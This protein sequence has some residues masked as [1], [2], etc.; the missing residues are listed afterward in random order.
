MCYHQVSDAKWLALGDEIVELLRD[1]P[2]AEQNI[3]E[4]FVPLCLCLCVCVCVSV[5]L[6][7]CVCA[8]VRVYVP[9][10]VPPS[11]FAR[12]FEKSQKVGTHEFII[13]IQIQRVARSWP[14]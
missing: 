3:V 11:A 14:P 12:D 2:M 13:V 1:G 9:R 8:C 7:L 4:K 5:C 6:C 10:S